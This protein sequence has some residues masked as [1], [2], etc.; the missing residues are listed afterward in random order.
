M[1]NQ[2]ND[3]VT[4]EWLLPLFNQQL[5]Q[6]SAGWQLG[7][8][9]IDHEQLTARYHQI[10]GAL[11]MI[12]LPLLAGIAGKLSQLVGL[13]NLDDF[14]I[15]ERRIGQFSHRLLQREINQYA[16]IGSYHTDLINRA[17]DE[18]TQALSERG[19]AADLTTNVSDVQREHANNNATNESILNSIEVAIPADNATAS[20]AS[21]QYQQLLLVWRQQVQALLVTNTNQPTLL[22]TLEKVSRYLWQTTQDNDLQRLWYLTELWLSDLSHNETPLPEYYAPLL[23]Q[24]D[25]VIESCTQSDELSSGTVVRL[26][27]SVYIELSYLAYSSKHTQSILDEVS[28]SVTTAP[29]FLPRLLNEL[30]TLIFQLDKP[31]T[32]IAPLQHMKR[33]LQSRGWTYYVSQIES[34]VADL[35]QSFVSETG[36]A[37]EQWQ[38]ERK[39]QE[40][41]SA[42]YSTEQTIS[43]KIGNATSFATVPEAIDGNDSKSIGKS[44]AISTDNGLR[45]LRIAVEEIKQNFNEYIQRQDVR[46]LPATADFTNIGQAFDDMGLPEIRQTIDDIGSVFAQL[47]THGIAVPSWDLIE[48][49]AESLTSVELLLDYLAQQV[50][51]QQLLTLANEHT[52]RA[53]QLFNTYIEAP[54]MLAESVLAHKAAVTDVL[55]Y[56]DSGEIVP[57]INSD[58]ERVIDQDADNLSVSTESDALK[59]AREK[60]KPDRFETDEEIHDI[61]IE[62]V[63]EVTADLEDFLPIWQQDPQDLTPLTEVRRGFHTLKGSGRMVGAFSI[64]EMAWSIEN[65]LNRLLD[66]TLP[67]TDD[68]VNLVIETTKNIPALLS[69]FEAQ[70]LPSFDPAITILQSSNLMEQQPL[71]T[72]LN[73]PDLKM[74]ISEEAAPDT[75]AAASKND[76]ELKAPLLASDDTESIISSDSRE[77]NINESLSTLEIPE[78]LAPFMKETEQLATDANDA[79]PDIKEIFIE[80]ANEVLVEIVPL[81]ENWQLEPTNLEPLKDIRRGFHTLK[82]SGRMVGAHYTAELAWSIENMLNRVLDNSVTTS[83]D[84]RQLIADVLAAYPQMLTVFENNT[85]DYPAVVPLWVACANAYSKQQSSEFS[86]SALFAQ[87]ADSSEVDHADADSSTAAIDTTLQTFYSVNEKMAEAPVNLTPQSEEEKVFCKIFI[88]EAEELLGH[89]DQFVTSNR[90]QTC[91]EVTDEIV[92]AFHTLRGAS[93]SS[94]LAAISEVSATIEHSLELLQQQDTGMNAQHLEALAQSAKLIDGYLSNYK[95]NDVSVEDERSQSQQDIA[96]LQAMLGEQYIINDATVMSD[97]KPTIEELLDSNIAALLDAE[98]EL[99]E[100]LS[101]AEH[102]PVQSYIEQQISQIASLVD[103][104]QAF[105]K[106]VTI[107]NELGNVYRY[108]SNN[109]DEARDKDV[110][111]VLHAGHAQLVG[112]FDALAGSTSLKIDKQILDELQSIYQEN[113][114][115]QENQESQE[116][117]ESHDDNE[118]DDFIVRATSAPELQLETIDTDVE[119]LEIFLEE[120]QELDVA[121][122]E[123][124]NKWRADITNIN[125]LKVLQRHLHTIKGGARMAGI[126]SIGDL[127]HEAESVYESFVEGRRVPTAQW[128]EIMQMVQDTMSLQV[129]HIVN[130]KKSFFTTTLI[131]QLQQLEK[132]KT[133]PE[134]VELVIPVPKNHFEP[135]VQSAVTEVTDHNKEALDTISLDRMIKQSWANGLPDPDILAV[136][137]EEA[138][139]LTNRNKYL[140]LFLKDTNNTTALQA[141]QRDL[142]TI[143]GGARMVTAAGIAD[144]AHE[145]ETVYTDFVSNRRPATKKVLELLVASH[146][147][148]ADAVF[149]LQQQVNPPTPAL[150]IEAL[151]QFSKNPDS[152]KTI[153]KESLQAQ[154]EAILIAKENQ[155]SQYLAK[156]IS[157]MPSMHR[158]ASEEDQNANS[159]EMIRISGGLIEHMINLS[160]ESA[161]NRARIDMG[162]SSLTN[163]IEEMGT[164][165]QRL[166]DQLRRMEIE[167]EAQILSQIDDELINNEGFDPLEMDQY[168]SLNQLSKSLTESASDLVDINHTLLEKTRDSESLLL[169]LSRTQTELQDG[170]MNSRMVPFTRLT[171]RLERIVRQTANELNKSVDLT[172]IN[173][174]DEMDR[175]ILERI[176][177]P[178]EHMLRNAVDHGIETTSARLKAGKERSGHITLEVSREGSEIVIQL[179]DDG[180]GIDVEAVRSKAI[181]QGLIDADD[182]SLTD[183]DIMQYIFN[184]GLS[185]SKQV[186]QISGRGVGMDVVI[187]EIRQLGGAVSVVSELGKGSRFTMRLPLTVAV[188]DALVVRAA[189]RYYAIPLVQIERV[190]RVNPEKLYDYYQSNDATLNFE[191]SDY[192]VRYLN[193]ILSGNKLNELVVNT[194][195]S[196]PLII[197]KNRTGQNIALQVDQIAG[198][199]I[200][201][202]VKPLGQQLSNI[203]GVSAATI[204]GDGSVMLI[205]DLIALMRNAQLVKNISKAAD[206][207]RGRIES[208]STILVVDD[209]VTVRKVTSRFLERQGFNVAVAKDG[210]DAIEIL[211]DMTPDMI[212]LDIEMPRMDGFEVATQVRHSKRLQHIPIIMIT[213]RTGEKHRERALEIGVNDYMGKPFQEKELLNK[214]QKLLGEGVSL[215]NEG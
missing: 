205:L 100:A 190:V 163:S 155:D 115:N 176:T 135:E 143:K 87:K 97:K 45:E 112:L 133:L 72:G 203:P 57:V 67:V 69:D 179:I 70:R 20:L 47:D 29:R 149:I 34:I 146:D 121:L 134:I 177:S 128:L 175:T 22:S 42:I 173:A 71:N 215:T 19:I 54:E 123:S 141:L 124:F 150:L 165:V 114:E 102:G 90:N 197:I 65:L 62:E 1:K 202:V 178:L 41:Y 33:Q 158:E 156:D 151:E 98:W 55:R 193:E 191:D 14:S 183:L 126:R 75:T 166:A 167:L 52:A 38:I 107:L 82:G 5:S 39:L 212:L 200:E 50:F 27:T 214:M 79:D 181:S 154:R 139:E 180:R 137:L 43:L 213:S 162:I 106:F 25:Q 17:T 204:M 140:H 174:D 92:R 9:S 159:N 211:Q 94:A 10:S 96:S 109:L 105:P 61:F 196:L 26:I 66:N 122:D 186:T 116:S 108:L 37:Q 2:P 189:D 51:D 171:P 12:N 119:L 192:R 103:N 131:E 99:G 120:A 31:A 60:T 84:M 169:Q 117:Q 110:Q 18:L 78:V 3:I 145:M 209:S 199:R 161:I 49:L 76:S 210:I 129:M 8:S 59:Q 188:S 206:A 74:A 11:V 148:L 89:I 83:A 28:K 80:E 138:E 147:W 208:K 111:A 160:G 32:L 64:S 152:L 7:E 95:H 53:I 21:E 127:T 16:R 24:L 144:L 198:S 113:Q 101:N 201:V 36:F 172:I 35:E 157:E 73:I 77:E 46:L 63:T 93:G 44:D 23:S 118:G 207:K 56:D 4:L 86:Y 168:S 85:Q 91:I 132:T 125:S 58:D 182:N 104:A 195:T 142:H 81:Y 164:T 15:K 40:L 194:N 30:E 88:D 153:P 48:A 13:E 185:T 170:L 136:F 68:V 187:S 184:A 130:T 6:V